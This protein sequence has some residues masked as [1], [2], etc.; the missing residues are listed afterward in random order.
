MSVIGLHKTQ[1]EFVT[2]DAMFSAL[3]C[4]R[5]FGKTKALSFCVLRELSEN[6]NSLG[7]IGSQNPSSLHTVLLKSI[8]Y[9]LRQAGVEFVFG[10]EPP[11]YTSRFQSHVNV[12]S[13][14]NGWQALCRSMHESGADRNIR[15]AEVSSIFLDEVREMTEDTFEITSACLRGPKPL[16]MHMSTTP[17]GKDWIWRKFVKEPLPNSA[18]FTGATMENKFLPPEYIEMLKS[19]YSTSMYRQEVLGQ[20]VQFME[21]AVY[22]FKERNI[23]ENFGDKWTGVAF[24]MDFNVSPLCGSII[25][26]NKPERK[27]WVVDEYW[28]EDSGSTRDACNWARPRLEHYRSE[29]KLSEAK[30]IGDASGGH[31]DTR[32]NQSDL[33]IMQNELGKCSIRLSASKKNPMVIDRINAVNTLLDPADNKPR[34]AVHPRCNHLIDDLQS[35]KFKEKTRDIDKSDKWLTHISDALGYLCFSLFPVG[36]EKLITAWKGDI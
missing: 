34:L 7:L 35:V 18:I 36:V 4:G 20:F 9:T 15:G 25:L 11:W 13:I 21:G 33:D 17:N 29:L 16:R 1:Y 19:L 22:S 24:G 28:K 31:R 23:T 12:L 14:S 30:F 26:Y 3:V 10:E 27:I 32:G 8:F 6:P 5:G 2:S